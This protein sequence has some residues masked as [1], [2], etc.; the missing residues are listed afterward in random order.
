MKVATK[1]R[2]RALIFGKYALERS[3]GVVASFESPYPRTQQRLRSRMNLG[4]DLYLWDLI[5]RE[6]QSVWIDLRLTAVPV[7]PC[8]S[9][10]ESE[11]S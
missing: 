9:S 8:G 2:S 7:L 6:S 10:A 3:V 11:G 4:I 1:N 5:F